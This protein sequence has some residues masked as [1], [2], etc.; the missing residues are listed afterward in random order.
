[1]NNKIE[2][3]NDNFFFHLNNESNDDD[4][5]ICLISNLPLEKNYITLPCGHK[6]N[7][8]PLF[9]EV[10]NQ[11]NYN[12]LETSRIKKYQ[13]KCP[14]CRT[15]V[16]NLL[17]FHY[18]YKQ[19]RINYVNM[20]VKYSL[21]SLPCQYILKSGVNCNNFCSNKTA[22]HTEY[23]TLCNK[24][25]LFNINKKIKE[26]ENICKNLDNIKIDEKIDEKIELKKLKISELKQILK[27]NN[28]KVSGNKQ[29]LINRIKL[30]LNY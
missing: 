29:E 4:N 30:K 25:Y 6:F 17:P 12:I 5:E 16:N 27:D 11:K 24:H 18:I 10:K 1:M 2:N 8:T 3:I 9:N 23:G 22:C 20:P 21:E 15:I 28:C 19:P 13:I 7:Y 26:A 14:Y